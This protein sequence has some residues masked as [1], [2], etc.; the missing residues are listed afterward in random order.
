MKRYWI[1]IGRLY[2][3]KDVLIDGIK[4]YFKWNIIWGGGI[5]GWIKIYIYKN[6]ISIICIIYYE[7]IN[8]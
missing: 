2:F 8:L 6:M 1:L 5:G 4:D 7:I 3:L